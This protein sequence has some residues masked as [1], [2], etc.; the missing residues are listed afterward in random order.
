MF[1]RDSC[2]ACGQQGNFLMN[3]CTYCSNFA[4]DHKSYVNYKCMFLFLGILSIINARME[5]MKRSLEHRIEESAKT[6]RELILRINGCE[7]VDRI[8][9]LGNIPDLPLSSLANF[10]FFENLLK[11]DNELRKKLVRTEF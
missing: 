10:M 3:F 4:N 2:K 11:T 5:S 9:A 6:T 7:D 8:M 1:H